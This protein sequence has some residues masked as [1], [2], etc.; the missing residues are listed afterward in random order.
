MSFGEISF[1]EQY[2]KAAEHE[3]FPLVRE[4]MDN[5]PRAFFR[6]LRKNRPVLTTPVCILVALFDDVVEVLRHHSVFTVEL[7]FPKM[8]DYML[9]QDD[10]PLH[11]REK[12]IMQSMLNRDDLPR[13]R[14]LI[15]TFSKETL[16]NAGSQ[17]EY[18]NN[19]CRLIPALLVQQYFGLD[20]TDPR[21]LIE[22]SYWN[23]YDTFHNQP[24]DIVDDP[25]AIHAKSLKG[26]QEMR[27]YLGDLIKRKITA[28]QKG[29]HAD[30]IVSRLLRTQFPE[31]VTFPLDRLARNIGGLLIGAVET[32]AQAVAQILQELLRRPNVLAQAK[33]AVDDIA[34]FDSIVWEAL[35][36]NP[37]SPYLFR[38]S[39]A[40]Y[41][42]A[43]GTDRETVI[44]EGSLVLP[45]ILSATF[46]ERAF[47]KPEKFNPDRPW[48]DTFHFGF[49]LHECLGKYIGMVMIPEMARQTLMRPGLQA[50]SAIDFKGGPFPEHYQLSWRKR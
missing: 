19:F 20:G 24:F 17:I 15:G 23:Q 18:V 45:L 48:L 34:H 14:E 44:P 32:T 47:S 12:A 39:I 25:D 42:L 40:D 7:Y 1:L 50:D 41:T 31:E 30:D 22:W 37:I 8:G 16:E 49:G 9:A 33:R 3:K 26:A 2:D 6:E 27:G 21:Q 10:T 35:R 38:K 13:V 5:N 43:R 11:Y 46:D 4:W 28:V 29:E 36:F